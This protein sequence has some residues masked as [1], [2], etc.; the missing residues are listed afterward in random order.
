MAEEP[1]PPPGR[2]SGKPGFF[3]NM[4]NVIAGVTGLV[5]A[6]GGLAAA[7]TTIFPKDQQ[8]EQAVGNETAG[9]NEA[10][11]ADQSADAAV[12][13]AAKYTGTLYADG[14]YEG[15]A[16]TLED[17]GENWVLT[18]GDNDPVLYEEVKSPYENWVM[19]YDKDEKEYL[20]W[21]MAGGEL[22]KGNNDKDNWRKYAWV[23]P[24]APEEPTQ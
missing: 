12:E 19:A 18:V 5:V 6:L 2:P 9:A 11:S 7:W 10:Q 1:A 20:S 14:K 13:K 16:V 23:D 22:Q 15:D 17:N 21:S 4:N 24:A 3:Q 8:Q